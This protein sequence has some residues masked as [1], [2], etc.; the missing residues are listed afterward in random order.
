MDELILS[1]NLSRLT[2]EAENSLVGCLLVEPE[3]TVREITGILS[4]GDFQ[5]ENAK[6]IYSLAVEL[7]NAGR[8]CDPVLI[9]SEDVKR[10]NP[11]DK[12]NK[13]RQR[14]S[15]RNLEIVR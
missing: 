4:E 2:A 9:Q 3:D 5:S 13:I 14:E 11:I 7:I 15:K 10:W 1:R 6:V 8:A 12:R